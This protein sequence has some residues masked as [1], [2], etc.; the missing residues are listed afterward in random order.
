MSTPNGWPS[1]R[2]TL[3]R[4]IRNTDDREAW[5]SFVDLYSPL[6]YRYCLRRGLQDA[7]ARDV[8]QEVFIRVGRGIERF[9]HDP[10]RGQFRA[11]LGTITFREIQRQR[12]KLKRPGRGCGG[13]ADEAVLAQVQTEH[14]AAWKAAF[15]AEVYQYALE[16]TREKVE[17]EQWRA[18]ELIWMRDEKPADVARHLNRAVEWVYK[19]KHR[20]LS[21]LKEQIRYF[22]SDLIGRLE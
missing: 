5:T 20:V 2:Y 1:T 18:F 4:R 13:A 3:L 10:A 16:R 14:E 19:A 11:W 8:V 15:D 21:R 22:T 6:V 9:E 12:E 7:D 17:P